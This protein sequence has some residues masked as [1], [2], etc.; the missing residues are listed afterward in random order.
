MYIK[1]YVK[2]YLFQGAFELKLLDANDNE[3]YD[4]TQT[5]HGANDPT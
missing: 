3:I 1:I 4:I 2:H 5:P